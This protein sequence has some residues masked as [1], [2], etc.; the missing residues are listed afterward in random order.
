MFW[1]KPKTASP[2]V[3]PFR[4]NYSFVH[5]YV[6]MDS[7]PLVQFAVTF[8]NRD[9]IDLSQVDVTAHI[10]L[11]LDISGSMN[12]ADKY[13]LLLQAIP[14]IIDALSDNDW[15]S[16]ILFSTRSELIWS[17]D[18]GSSRSRKQEII[19]RIDQSGVKFEQTYL[20]QGLRL[21]IDEIKYFSQYRP[22][23]VN[24][25]YILTDGQLHDAELCYQLNPELRNLNVEINSYGF[26]QDFAEET[27]R[28]IM[29]GCPGGRVKC[30]YNQN[31]LPLSFTHIGKV[32]GNLI[33]TDAELEL[34]FSPNVIPGDAFRFEPGT[35]WF[36]SIDG[37]TRLFSSQIGG[38]EKGRIY[39]YCFETRLRQSQKDREQ[40]A[41][42]T[43][44]YNFKGHKETVNQE[45]FINRS[46]DTFR[47]SMTDDEIAGWFFWLDGL[48]T[49]DPKAQMDSL[50]S[51]LKILLS[52]GSDPDHIKLIEQAIDKLEKE[53]TLDGLSNIQKRRLRANDRS[54]IGR[55][56]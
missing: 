18:I 3:P 48:R 14:C 41:T 45:I 11:V 42:A 15:L 28:Q 29:A 36:G 52:D 34:R 30:I 2:K 53:G 40:I 44:S 49:N 39:K 24:R 13:P 8:S 25:L 12:T 54:T 56:N 26:G 37:R 38:L 55:R 16:I 5:P 1:N 51:Q 35:K 31:E 9:D 46:K 33:A 23:A 43:L 32:A 17:N 21:A 22:D 19:Q 50:K 6:P 4:I 47:Y 10:C 20:S 27:I 7:D